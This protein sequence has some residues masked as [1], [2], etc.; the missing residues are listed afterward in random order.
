METLEQA[1]AQGNPRAAYTLGE[2]HAGLFRSLKARMRRDPL[3]ACQWYQIAD[4]LGGSGNWSQRFPDDAAA[5]RNDLEEKV[6]GSEN[7]LNTEDQNSC[8]EQA[9]HWLSAHSLTA[10]AN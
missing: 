1:A 4:K 7:K 9:D 6:S 5:L 10:K 3:K 2:I 8:Q